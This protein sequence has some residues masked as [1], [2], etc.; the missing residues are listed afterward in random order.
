MKKKI[1]KVGSI[2]MIAT[3]ML[4]VV[5]V[6]SGC[7]N[8][9]SRMTDIARI[10]SRLGVALPE[11]TSVIFSWWRM[12]QWG[13]PTI[14]AIL[15]LEI[16]PVDLLENSDFEFRKSLEHETPLNFKV[17]LSGSRFQDNDYFIYPNWDESFLWAT[18]NKQ[19]I[20]Y[21]YESKIMFYFH[22]D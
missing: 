17:T 12:T 19:F 3:L 13:Y 2:L 15:E 1:R 11:N 6:T 16:E 8:R 5:F 18:G 9:Y 14:Y 22:H 7:G 10:E 21:F 4:G 20:A